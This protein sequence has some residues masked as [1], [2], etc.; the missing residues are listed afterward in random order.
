MLIFEGKGLRLRAKPAHFVGHLQLTRSAS[1]EIFFSK[2]FC[3][4]TRKLVFYGHVCYDGRRV[5]RWL[6][7]A[8]RE[9]TMTPVHQKIIDE[10]LIAAYTR[11]A[12]QISALAYPTAKEEQYN[13]EHLSHSQLAQDLTLIAQYVEGYQVEEDPQQAIERVCRVLFGRVGAVG[14]VLPKK[15][16]K[17]T[18]GELIYAAYEQLIPRDQLVTTDAARKAFGVER[19]SI[20]DWVE[21]GKLSP[22]YI[23]GKQMFS[24]ADIQHQTQQRSERLKDKQV[25][26][27]VLQAT[28]KSS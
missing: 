17:T 8:E 24:S 16:H 6:F 14:Y 26:N 15:F 18:L 7:L 4:L 5:D 20:Y 11:M 23:K 28:K 13:Q 9:E 12:E 2:Q 27:N 21:E 3:K 1:I 22:Y 19:Q 25:E 10:T